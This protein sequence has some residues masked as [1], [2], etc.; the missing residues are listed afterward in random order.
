M[1]TRY[2]D[3]NLLR[4]SV[5]EWTGHPTEIGELDRCGIH[6][7]LDDEHLALLSDDGL[8]VS[9]LLLLERGDR[10][11]LTPLGWMAY[12]QELVDL[13]ARTIGERP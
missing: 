2:G 6:Y 7:F 10:F 13:L 4:Y 8:M 9:R 12:S 1:I 3:D 5:V 11:I